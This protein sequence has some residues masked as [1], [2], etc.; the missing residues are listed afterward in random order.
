MATTTQ[1]LFKDAGKKRELMKLIQGYGNAKQDVGYCRATGNPE[2]ES[3]LIE[4]LEF[5]N[6]IID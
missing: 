6:K 4:L 2:Y 3:K 1:D 5:Y